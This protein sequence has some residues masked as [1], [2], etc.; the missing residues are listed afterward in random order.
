MKTTDSRRDGKWLSGEMVDA[1]ETVDGL[2]TVGQDAAG[3]NP[4]STTPVRAPKKLIVIRFRLKRPN[5]DGKGAFFKKDF[6]S[7]SRGSLFK[8]VNA[9]ANINN[10]K[11]EHSN[12]KIRSMVYC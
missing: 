7:K 3:S 6:L 12:R 8:S 11:N 2:K 1:L 10:Y 9:P 5:R 4:A